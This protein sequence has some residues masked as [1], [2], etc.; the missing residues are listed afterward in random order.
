MVKLIIDLRLDHQSLF[1]THSSHHDRLVY[2]SLITQPFIQTILY[3]IV[4]HYQALLAII[5]WP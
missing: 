1:I 2:Q 3:A 4:R 5:I